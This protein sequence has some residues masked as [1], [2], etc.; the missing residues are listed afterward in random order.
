MRQPPPHTARYGLRRKS[1]PDNSTSGRK[2]TLGF[3]TKTNEPVIEPS[4]QK[5]IVPHRNVDTVSDALARLIRKQM[6]QTLSPIT[7][8][9]N[10]RQGRIMQKIELV[11]SGALKKRVPKEN[12]FLTFVDTSS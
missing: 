8:R 9:E 1:K 12:T 2:T 11:E 7:L 10:E 4:P 6:K 3:V 5:L